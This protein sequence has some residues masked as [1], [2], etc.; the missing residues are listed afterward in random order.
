MCGIVGIVAHDHVN[1]TLYDAITVL[2]HRGQD[3]AGIVTCENNQLHL[4][5]DNGS[6]PGCVPHPSHAE[7]A[8]NDRHWSHI[9]YPTAGCRLL[10]RGATLLRQFALWDHPCAQRQLDQRG[11]AE[12]RP[13]P[14]GSAPHQHRVRFRD[15]VERFRPR[16]A[17]AREDANRP[18]RHFRGRSRCAPPLRR[19]L[20]RRVDDHRL[21]DR[22]LSRPSRHSPVCYG[23][24]E[25]PLGA[26]YMV[27]SE[28]VALHALG[29]DLVRDLEPG[30]AIFIDHAAKVFTDSARRIPCTRRASSSLC[31]SHARFDHRRCLGVQGPSADGRTSG[32]QDPA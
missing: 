18:Q 22:R 14:G 32:R 6:G 13:L 25:T 28:S 1:Q 11:G 24:R 26:E 2:Q 5:K 30:E 15:L 12:A 9:R 8:R 17:E 23:K 4:R 27:A 10:G 3:A 16:V 21:W 19:W 7:P 31:T 20:R 29:F